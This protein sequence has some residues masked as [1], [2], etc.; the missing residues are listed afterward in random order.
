M[1][2][3][4]RATGCVI[5]C[6]FQ[7]GFLLTAHPED[8]AEDIA[9][10]FTDRPL[11]PGKTSRADRAGGMKNEWEARRARTM[12]RF[13]THVGHIANEIAEIRGLFQQWGGH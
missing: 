5:V 9:K 11:A 7:P 2:N 8:A 6:E 13:Q 10:Q 12:D 1:A 3:L 4:A